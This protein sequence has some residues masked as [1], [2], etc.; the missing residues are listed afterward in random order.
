MELEVPPDMSLIEWSY[1]ELTLKKIRDRDD[2]ETH[3]LLQG[4][5]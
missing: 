1:V 4:P 3:L 2:L 5:G